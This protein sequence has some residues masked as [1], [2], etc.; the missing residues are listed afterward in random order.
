LGATGT[1]NTNYEGKV[2]AALQAL[3]DYDLVIVHLE[4]P[5]ECSH[6]GDLQAKLKAIENFDARI[7]G[8]IL[9]ALPAY[10]AFKI[11]CSCDHYTPV[12][13]KTHSSDPVPFVFYD[14]QNPAKCGAI[15]YSEKAAAM[16]PTLI[17][18]G[19]SLG[20]LF[21]GRERQ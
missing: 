8:P 7:V 17:P 9:N 2:A 16:V 18:D 12:M 19:P 21:F 13:K 3:K 1:L 14:S 20:L 15:G 11:L 10:G 5:D 4:A 6:Q